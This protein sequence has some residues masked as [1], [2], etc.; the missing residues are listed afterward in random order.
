M[1]AGLWSWTEPGL[2]RVPPVGMLGWAFFAGA[3]VAGLGARE[4]RRAPAAELATVVAAPAVTHGLLLA[5]WWGLL[6]W[7]SGEVP[8]A[9]AA[10]LAWG[11]LLPVAAW[12][13]RRGARLGVPAGDLLLRLP[14]ALFFFV[15]L[16]IHGRNDPVLVG[17]SLAFAPP[18]LALM[19]RAGGRG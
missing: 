15:L 3:C 13:F 5:A 7:V 16:A 12:A 10:A 14:G 6:R 19:A 1:R 11:A 4:G 17:W 18:Y 9:P 8:A 2:F